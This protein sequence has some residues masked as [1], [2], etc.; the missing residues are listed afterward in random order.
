M[1]NSPARFFAAV[2]LSSL[3]AG[4][5]TP[6]AG[7]VVLRH[8]RVGSTF[9]QSD[10]PLFVAIAKGYFNEAGIEVE[11]IPYRNPAAM[12]A[13]LGSGQIDAGA[14]PPT[15]ELFN[16][17]RGGVDL[18]IVATEGTSVPGY[19]AISLLVRRGLI[20]S[21]RVKSFADLKG[22]AF[23]EAGQGTDAFL[24]MSA[25]LRRGSLTY[26][27]VRPGRLP[28]PDQVLA[29]A[30]GTIDAATTVEPFATQA[31]KSDAAI[32]F[33]SSDVLA[34]NSPNALL[35]YS[36]NFV[37]KRQTVASKFMLA[38]IRALR[39]YAGALRGGRLAGI[40]GA[41][42]IEILAKYSSVKDPALLRLITPNAV[43][44]NGRLNVPALNENLAAVQQAG[45]VPPGFTLAPAID[46]S[47]VD[48]ALKVLGT[49]RR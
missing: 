27:D 25:A 45:L 8:V 11:L 35:F 12:M 4:A 17:V 32:K 13:A 46:Q 39:Y 16:A 41:D 38:Y 22:L 48:A 19:G 31:I 26:S 5:T 15:D 2:L 18:K 42:V 40:H 6:A 23:A 14:G 21:G 34:P 49:Y 30:R 20:E 7:D 33:S 10:A 37:R 43:D 29:F 28:V 3:L 36:G 47:F 44:V 9:A 24:T 1:S